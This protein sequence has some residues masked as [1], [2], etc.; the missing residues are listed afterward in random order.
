VS[1]EGIEARLAAVEKRLAVLE[2]A[3]RRPTNFAPGEACPS[4]G[5]L[6]FR[7][8]STK[9]APSPWDT[10]GVLDRTKRCGHCEHEETT[11]DGNRR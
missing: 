6:A 8:V 1:N 4:C 3:G 5:A 11:R 7:T 2:E 9:P 10:F